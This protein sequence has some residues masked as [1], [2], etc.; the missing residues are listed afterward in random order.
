[1]KGKVKLLNTA[2]ESEHVNEIGAPHSVIEQVAAVLHNPSPAVLAIII[3][4]EGPA[5]RP[6]GATMVFFSD[7]SR[8][9]SLSSGCIEADLAIHAKNALQDGQVVKLRY[10]EG[11]RFID[12]RLPCGGGLDVLLVP[13]PDINVIKKLNL[14]LIS[15]QQC[16]L[17]VNIETGQLDLVETHE[18]QRMDDDFYIK[19]VPELKFLVFGKG[20]EAATF[21]SL[22]NVSNYQNILF[23]PDDETIE[24]ATSNGCFTQHLVSP[25]IEKIKNADRWT[26][27]V[28]FFHDHDW[29]PEIIKQALKTEAFYIGAQGSKR[30]NDARLAKLAEDGVSP[31]NLARLHGPIGMIKSVRDARTLAV[32]VLAEIL[33]L[34]L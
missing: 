27:I 23:S 3:G 6:L 34:S 4:I 10:G 33:D 29:E 5:Y 21:A 8:F 16:S 25:N 32:S 19:F 7:G 12:I 30:T 22:V 1:M 24:T 18:T 14:K 2:N 15:R 20:P 17:K 11:S 28:L 9:G 31:K 13:N 26:A